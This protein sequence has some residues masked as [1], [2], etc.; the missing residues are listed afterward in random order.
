MHYGDAQH[1]VDEAVDAGISN[2]RLAGANLDG[3]NVERCAAVAIFARSVW[4]K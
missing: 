2:Q 3:N 1:F 4:A